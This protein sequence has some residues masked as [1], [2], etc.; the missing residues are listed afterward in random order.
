MS[1][2]R[3][4]LLAGLLAMAQGPALAAGDIVR[5]PQGVDRI[6][7]VARA[8]VPAP[9]SGPGSG[10]DGLAITIY[11]ARTIVTLNP[12]APEAEAVAVL[13]GRILSV[14][15]LEE[16][17]GWAGIREVEIDRRFADAVL[18]PGFIEAHMHALLT[19]ILW[20][21]VYVG[22]FDRVA[23]DGR[24]VRGLAT[25]QEVLE[26]LAMAAAKL[27]DDGSWLIA[28]GYQ[29]EYYNDS[30][31]TRA[32]LDPIAMGH[33]M[34]IEN[35]S[36]HVYYVNSKALEVAGIGADTTV[37]GILKQDGRPTGELQEMKAVFA[38]LPKLPPLNAEVLLR[39]LR[40]AGRMAHRAGVTTFTDMNFGLVP[41]AYQAYA[42]AAAD[43]G[44]PVRSM[45]HPVNEIFESGPIA[46]KGGLDHLL[47]AHAKDSDRLS[48]GGVK[49]IVDGSIQAGTALFRWPYYYRTLENGVANISQEDLNRD[50]LEVHKRGLQAVIHTNG[51]KATDMA[52]DAIE[53][54]Q[55]AHPMPD[56]RHRLEHNQFPS[57][58]QLRRMQ[59]LDVGTSLFVNHI[60]YWGDLHY[61]TYL[62]P[63]RA[64]R[65]DPAGSAQRLGIPYSIHS[66]ASVTPLDPLMAMWVAVKRETMSGRVLG[67]S[68]RLTV[69]QALHA[70]TLG[71]A[72]LMKQDDIKG[73]IE[74]GKLAD[75]TVLDRNPLTLA[76]PDELRQVRV[77]G[78]VV[79]GVAFPAAPAR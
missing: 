66:D 26:R 38:F 9:D 61:S 4:L 12:A 55:K 54:A 21:G 22:R 51:D 52:L 15:S 16:V 59:A 49:F 13:D 60:Y 29:P 30:P 33:P 44:F 47:Q 53:A 75:F 56:A 71:A 46:E 40:D 8:S 74:T 37:E 32:D 68:E 35:L 76:D 78:T 70:V 39:S 69:P 73:S 25:R 63:D 36:M 18:V 14:G 42:A 62:G 1:A 27:P 64:E 3:H 24:T 67:A 77:L 11:P 2:Y 23:P 48:L 7:P 20:Q 34:F 6:E 43:P 50:V 58:A 17:T 5:P 57:Q 65:M 28:W 72:R 79:G 31:L 19:G 45:L 10:P 41:G